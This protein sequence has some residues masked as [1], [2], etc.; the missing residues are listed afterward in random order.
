[1]EDEEDGPRVEKQ[2]QA[3]NDEPTF[4]F[5]ILDLAQNTNMKNINRSIFPTFHGMSTKDPNAF[6]FEFDILCRSYNCINDAQKLKLFP[7]TLKDVSLR[8]FL[9]LGE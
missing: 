1:M 5:P 6:L 7:A 9:G 4:G 8:W 2:D 3:K